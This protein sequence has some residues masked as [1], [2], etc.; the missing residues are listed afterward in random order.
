[1]TRPRRCAAARARWA[2]IVAILAFVGVQLAIHT[3]AEA[4]VLPR[5]DPVSLEKFARLQPH[6][7]FFKDAVPT[8]T[9]YLMLGSSRTQLGFDAHAFATEL[10]TRSGRDVIAF[11]FGTPAG[12]PLTN[13]LYLRRLLQAGVQTDCLLI[14][15]HPAYLAQKRDGIAFEAQWLHSYRLRRGEP[16]VLA[17]F[18]VTP[19]DAPH[20]T[21]AEK[22]NSAHAY[23]FPMLDR[24]AS[25]WL[26]SSFGL[27]LGANTD[28][29]GHV[30]GITIAEHN[31][32]VALRKSLEQYAGVFPGYT[33]GGPGER[34]VADLVQ[35]AHANGWRVAAY[36]SPESTDFRAA[37]GHDSQAKFDAACVRWSVEWRIP[38]LQSRGWVS[39]DGF[40]D[41]HHATPSGSTEFSAKMVDAI[42]SECPP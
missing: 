17:K 33:I 40:A 34:A 26:P 11:N 24:Y 16:E 29:F 10:S 36:V 3:A 22:L 15:L 1:M 19:H 41:G 12:G 9:R 2:M 18:G 20:F 21:L 13:A 5:R 4:D 23:R 38:V 8:R 32:P 27:T 7:A 39:D 14:E 42:T 6:A 28:P 30:S 37:Y 35:L 31:K 25:V